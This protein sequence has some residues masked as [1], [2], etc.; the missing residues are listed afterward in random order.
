MESSGRN[1]H[2]FRLRACSM[3]RSWRSSQLSFSSTWDAPEPG[4]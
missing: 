2:R 4:I 3:Q 1:L